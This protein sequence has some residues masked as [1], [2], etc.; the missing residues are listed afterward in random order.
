[1]EKLKKCVYKDVLYELRMF[2]RIDVSNDEVI[3][4]VDKYINEIY[5]AFRTK[6]SPSNTEPL[7]YEVVDEVKEELK[8]NAYLK[9]QGKRI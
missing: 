3:N 2:H 1:M 7:V 4:L 6:I 9:S 8:Y 5:N